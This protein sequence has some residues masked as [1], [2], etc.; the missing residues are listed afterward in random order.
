VLGV[1]LRLSLQRSLKVSDQTTKPWW[2]SKTI[3]INILS[4]VIAILGFLIPIPALG[5]ILTVVVSVLNII[6]RLVTV[7]PIS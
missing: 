1:T 2:Q 7:L 6:L 3:I 5:P 4:I